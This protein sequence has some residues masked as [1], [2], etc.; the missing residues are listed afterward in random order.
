MK[1][2][3]RGYDIKQYKQKTGHLSFIIP[4]LQRVEFNLRDAKRYID[5]FIYRRRG[6]EL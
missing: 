3:Y 5:N 1:I 6:G 2:R 4:M